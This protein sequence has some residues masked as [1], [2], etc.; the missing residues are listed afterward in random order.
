MS[1]ITRTSTYDGQ[2]LADVTTIIVSAEAILEALSRDA[3]ENYGTDR[4]SRIRISPPLEGKKVGTLVSIDPRHPPWEEEEEDAPCF[5]PPHVFL[6]GS[7]GY[8]DDWNTEWNYPHYAA[9]LARFQMETGI[10]K[11]ESLTPEQQEVW[12]HA[13]DDRMMA[14][15]NAVRSAL[16]HEL[17]LASPED[18]VGPTTVHVSYESEY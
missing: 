1:G 11:S 18:G 2:R 9:E 10:G 14:W 3:I 13:W 4:R 8:D 7:S 17:E 16:S 12:E 6:T 15:E 5:L